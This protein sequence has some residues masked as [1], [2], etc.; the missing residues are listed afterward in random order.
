MAH[1]AASAE[2][3]IG[4]SAPFREMLELVAGRP[5]EASVLLAGRSGTGKEL[6]ARAVHE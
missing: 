1:G 6:V 4:R 5:L 2:G 3:L